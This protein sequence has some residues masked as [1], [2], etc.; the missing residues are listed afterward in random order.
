MRSPLA[1]PLSVLL[2]ASSALPLEKIGVY[3]TLAPL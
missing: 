1:T 3:L 2:S